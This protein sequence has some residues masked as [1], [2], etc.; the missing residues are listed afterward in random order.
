MRT[1]IHR[2]RRGRGKGW[3]ESIPKQ[4]PLAPNL[5]KWQITR[6]NVLRRVT[7]LLNTR[8]IRQSECIESGLSR[9]AN[10]GNLENFEARSFYIQKKIFLCI[11]RSSL[12]SPN[13]PNLPNSPNSLNTRQIRR[14][15]SQK[16]AQYS[17]NLPERVTKIWRIFGEY[18]NSLN[19]PASGHCLTVYPITPL[20]LSGAYIP[21]IVLSKT[22]IKL[23]Y[24]SVLGKKQ[25]F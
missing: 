10:L 6:A 5:P 24:V 12:P 20:K 7:F 14:S 1:T 16:F 15:E 18:S 22:N 13:L 2:Y 23:T 9:V 25:K 19:L 8:Q 11:K 17:P 4:W 3:V 21:S